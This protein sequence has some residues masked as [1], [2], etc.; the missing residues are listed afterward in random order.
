[1]SG[2]YWFEGPDFK[3]AHK[4][5]SVQQVEDY[6][7]DFSDYPMDVN[8]DG[9]LDIITGGWWGETLRWRENP[10]GQPVEWAVHDIEKTGSVERGCFW[11][12][13][14]DGQVEAVPNCPGRPF[15]AFKL[16]CDAKGKGTGKFRKIVLSETPQGHGLGF[17]DINGDGRN[18]LIS[19]GGWL[20]APKNPLTDKATTTAWRGGNR[21]STAA[22]ARGSSTTSTRPAPSTTTCNS[23]IS[24]TTASSNWSRAS[25]TAR[26]RNTTPARWTPSVSTTSR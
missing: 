17:G 5:C 13:D 2:E 20:E 14:G 26:I 10:K 3:K 11:D 6:Y 12:I 8:G 22:I 16:E 25:V 7:D 21:R 4:I 9:Y 24:T 18:D 1:M 19:A 15:V 23:W